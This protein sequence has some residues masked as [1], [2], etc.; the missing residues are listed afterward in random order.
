MQASD[1]IQ[2]SSYAEL[3]RRLLFVFFGL[4]IFRVGGHIPVPGVDLARLAGIF[5]QNQDGLLGMFNM[6]SGGALSRLSVFSLSL[7]PYISASIIMQLMSLSIPSLEALRK[8]GA[9]GNKK[10]SQYTRYLTVCLALFQSVGMAKML[11]SQGLV[12]S[13]GPRFYLIAAVS[14]TTGT[15]FLMWLGEQITEKGI[16]NGISLLIFAG[17][18]SRLPAAFIQLMQQAKQG[19][20]NV[21]SLFFVLSFIVAI[22]LLVVF[23]ERGQ[24][25]IAIQHPKRHQARAG[26]NNSGG[27]LPLKINM[28]GV[29]PPIFAS[30]IILF[31]ASLAGMIPQSANFRW[32]GNFVSLLSPGQPLYILLYISAIVFFCFFYTALVFNP[33]DIAD[34]L[35]KSG[36]LIPGIR[37]GRQ[38]SDF[39]DKVMTRLTLSGSVYLSVVALTPDLLV[40]AWHVPFYFGGTSLLIVVVV[41]MDFMAQLQ[42]HLIPERYASMIKKAGHSRK[43]SLLR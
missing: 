20:M 27:V 38:T 1:S 25:K 39:V 37:P 8:E 28:A 2:N 40:R 3:K 32:L 41:V 5:K 29:I 17:I 43:V 26:Q 12:L 42:S 21:V 7:M 31:P 30:A 34:N 22:T 18:V 23:I 9:R 36:A 16:G 15:L 10:I 11:I 14:L 35:K 19:Q 33:N 24:R 4:V 6:F 13:I